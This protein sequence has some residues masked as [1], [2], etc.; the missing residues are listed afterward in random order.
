MEV[1]QDAH[2]RFLGRDADRPMIIRWRAE[3][4]RPHHPLRDL[5]NDRPGWGLVSA[6]GFSPHFPDSPMQ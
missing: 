6:A 1:R 3:A 5:W 4:G 2:P